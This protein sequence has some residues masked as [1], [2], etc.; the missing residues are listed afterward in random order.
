M[1]IAFDGTALR[2]GRTGVGYYTEHL[3]HHLARTAT[4]D[5]LI[6][7]SNRAIDTTSPLPSRVRVATPARRV[8][9]MVWMQTLAVTAL[10]EV[11]ADVGH[12]TNGMLPLM[13][14]V[15]TVVTIHDM[16]LRLYPRYHPARRVLLNRPLVDVAAR[17]ADAIITVSESAKRDIVR[18]YAID[19][20]RVHVVYEAAAPAFPPIEDADERE[21]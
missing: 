9:R 19:P 20:D 7:V 17:R 14:P 8:P 4:D 13:S 1:R 5:E 10:R 15:P 21:R 2:P 3:L 6:V 11:E 18:L 16:S 12:F